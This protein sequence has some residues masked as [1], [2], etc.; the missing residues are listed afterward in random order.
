[1][2]QERE[3]P[4]PVGVAPD[5]TVSA[6]TPEGT[7]VVELSRTRGGFPEV[8][9][10]VQMGLASS[11]REVARYPLRQFLALVLRATRAARRRGR[12]RAV[13]VAAEL[14][15]RLRKAQRLA[16]AK[17]V[18]INFDSMMQIAHA[19]RRW[20]PLHSAITH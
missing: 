16:L 17:F 13:L 9:T 19:R 20:T 7:L 18:R 5:G 12:A 8:V 10:S 2:E 15:A 6:A 1:M 14:P 4:I 11:P 3:H